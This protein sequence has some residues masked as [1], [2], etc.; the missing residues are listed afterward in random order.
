MKKYYI[1]LI[2]FALQ[3]TLFINCKDESKFNNT[4]ISN[5]NKIDYIGPSEFHNFSS[6]RMVV[7]ENMIKNTKGDIIKGGVV[8]WGS[9][10]SLVLYDTNKNNPFHEI[11]KTEKELKYKLENKQLFLSEDGKKWEKVNVKVINDKPTKKYEDA[12]VM[13]VVYFES[14][15]INGEY[16]LLGE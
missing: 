5:N 13:M 8:E 3:L 1:L 15:W 9:K 7:S 4:I 11:T 10:T 14:K 6:G 2:I 12:R 16:E